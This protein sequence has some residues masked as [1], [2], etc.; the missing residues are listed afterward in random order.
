MVNIYPY[1]TYV[2]NPSIDI[3]YALGNPGAPSITDSGR[4]YTNL[5]DAQ[6]DTLISAMGRVGYG[7]VRLIIGESG[8][9]SAG[10]VAATTD[11]ARTYNQNLVRHVLGGT[12]SPLR[13]GVN[14]PTYIFALFNE[15]A[16]PDPAIER[17]FGLYRPDKTPVYNVN[18]SV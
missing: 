3:N 14:F 7:E 6:V 17:N 9:P 4:T 13:P 11:N 15:N 2:E 18:L 8:W 1:F 10:G 16:K 5:L 12:G